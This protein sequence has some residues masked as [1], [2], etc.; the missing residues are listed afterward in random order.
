MATGCATSMNTVEPAQPS[1]Q[2]Q[3]IADK[4]MISDPSLSRKVSIVGLNEAMT[5]GG[6]KQIQVEV[7]N[8]TRSLQRFNY[9][10][11]WFDGAG[12]QVNTPLSSGM[13]SMTIE[14]RESKYIRAVAPNPN[15]VDFK[16]Q[17]IEAN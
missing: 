5:P 9:R 16:I 17:F 3:M 8:A 2:K 10:V 1:Y 11:Q 13:T 15:V 4:R 12:M 7:Y 14:G 6:V